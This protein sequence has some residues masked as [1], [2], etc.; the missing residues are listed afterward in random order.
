[1]REHFASRF[2]FIMAAAGA[3]VGLGNI[4]G[5]PTQAASNGGG[6]FLVAYLVLVLILAFPM[7]IMEVAIGRHGQ[8]NPVDSVRKLGKTR[9]QKQLAA[10]VGY[11][12]MLVPSLVLSFY[13]IVAGW[14]LAFLAASVTRMLGWQAATGWLEAFGLG[15]NIVW[16]LVFYL[17]TILVVQAGVR[18]G[19]E[20]WSARLMPAL[21]VLFILLFGYILTQNGAME[22]LR[23]YLVPDFSKVMDSQLLISAMGQA[24][25]SLTIGGCSM[26]M[27]GSYLSRQESIPATAFQVTLLDTGVAFL[28]GLVI[29]P[30][31]FVAMHNGV[32]IYA[33][34][35][36]LLSSD[37]LV[38][39]V[40]PA[41]FETMGPVGLV[42]ALV[43]FVLMG[44]A[45]LTS[46]IS[47]LEVPVS[48]T[49]ERFNAPR[50]MVTWLLGGALALFSVVICLNFGALFGFV[51]R[52]STQNIQPLVG[53]GFC[54]LGGWM[55]GR[56]K[57]FDELVKGTPELAGS[58]F[59]RIWP[60]YVRLVCP[61][62][63]VLVIAASW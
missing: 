53:L 6:A 8:A 57:L 4:W 55:W 23:H 61:L 29:L 13:A 2:G 59:W 60:W 1:M 62:L 10:L 3:A 36:S 42:M 24:F 54:V 41:L 5:F 35:G 37:T 58:L 14:L 12:G 49:T 19:I 20:R 11:A 45:A 31:M 38:F 26:L 25:F 34:D 22:G 50:P 56:A 9:L 39:E 47:M 27:Y 52:L 33:E 32:T 40:L 46:S 28:A 7:L 15:R 16:T 18:K 21:F 48:Y 44:I 30:A 43:F 51:I 63:V 17:L